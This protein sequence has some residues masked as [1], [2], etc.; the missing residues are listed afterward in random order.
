[1]KIILLS[2]ISTLF[3]FANELNE[4]RFFGGLSQ[5]EVNLVKS[6]KYVTP[7]I[8]TEKIFE[9]TKPEDIEKEV[10]KKNI[11]ESKK[12]NYAKAFAEDKEGHLFGGI[13]Q[14]PL[15]LN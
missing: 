8:K 7:E 4:A 9:A 5:N 6:K 3:L 2:L 13:S 11:Q 1:M 14:N 15:N 12:G 10:M